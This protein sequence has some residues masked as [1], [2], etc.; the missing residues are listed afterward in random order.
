MESARYEILKD[1]SLEESYLRILLCFAFRLQ[2]SSFQHVL[3]AFKF[4][5]NHIRLVLGC[6]L[7][8]N[9]SIPVRWIAIVEATLAVFAWG[10]TFVATKIA[11]RYITPE[12]IVWLRFGIGV[13]FLGMVVLLRKQFRLPKTKDYLYFAG[14]G[15]IGITFHQWLQSTGMVTSQATTTAWIVATTP[16]FMAVFGRIFLKEPLSVIQKSGIGLAALGV[17]LVVTQGDF[18]NLFSGRIG[19]SGD[20][21]ILLS[22]PNWAVFSTL[23]RRGLRQYPATLM[24]FYVMTFGWLF[25]NLIFFSGQGL[26]QIANLK[27]DGW[28]AIAFLGLFGSGFAYVF[29]YDA[30]KVLPVAQAG[31]FVYLEPFITVV[32][33]SMILPEPITWSSILG[34]IGII[35][36]VWLVNARKMGFGKI[37]KDSS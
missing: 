16:I 31:A 20:I 9:E 3:E 30:L 1:Y 37:N 26:P 5:Q 21:L 17:L 27:L 29:W 13:V 15:F 36:G 19:A 28:I 33:A 11:L 18:T 34:G 22:A 7:L 24:I 35:A 32:V 4:N 2:L 6:N 14:I 12:G 10:I 8:N 25:S 23:S